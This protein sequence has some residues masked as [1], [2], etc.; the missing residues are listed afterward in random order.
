MPN[1]RPG[2]RT[3]P[4][5]R[6]WQAAVGLVCLTA[7]ILLGA[8]R[9]Y[10]TA[11]DTRSISADLSS[12]IRD[13]EN[14]LAG[15]DSRARTLQ[16]DIDAAAAQD[17]SP[18]VAVALAAAGGQRAN[19]QLEAVTGPAV[20]VS[21]DDAQRD[22]DGNYPTGVN[23][24]DLVVHQQDVQAVVNALWA[25]GAEAMTIMDQRVI[26]T[27][28][29]RCIGNTLLLQGR[30]YSPP[31]VVTAIGDAAAMSSELDVEPG[32]QLLLQ[33]VDK[34]QLG[35]EVK[36]LDDAVLPAYDGPVRMTTARQ[37][38]R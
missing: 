1:S 13:Q 9:G 32:V 28:A 11:H 19:A 25:G 16:Q 34:Y 35:Y 22:A 2:G 3:G 10:F 18:E 17:V 20:R 33:Y 23:P 36:V 5:S 30:T 7:G 6:G 27:S 31:F 4:R 8:V 26:A 38:G 37:E 24:D 14:R 12:V 15:A 21:L 29:V